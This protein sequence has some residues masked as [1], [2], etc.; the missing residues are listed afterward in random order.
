MYVVTGGAGFIGSNLVRGLNARGIDDI[1]VVDDL[2]QGDKFR[3]LRGAKI[4][5]YI[6]RAE[7]RGSVQ[8]G[9]LPGGVDA[10]FHQGACADT[11]E[12]NGRYMLDNNYAYS[13][14][15]LQCALGK[16]IPF[17]YA[18]SASVY[19]VNRASA[20]DP[21]NENPLNVYAYSKWLFDEYVRRMLP[22]AKSTVAGLRY[23][24]V[25]GPAER[26]KGRM[27]SMVYRLYGQLAEEGKARIFR[28]T[29]GFG[30]GEQRRDFVFVGD[31][32][33]VN[34]F[35][36]LDSVNDGQ[37]KK[38]IFN[39]GTGASRSFNDVA[40]TL[41]KLLGRGEVEHIPFPEELRGKYQSFTE[42]DVSGLRAAGY[43]KPFTSIED[44]VASSFAEWQKESRPA[45]PPPGMP[46]PKD[47]G[48]SA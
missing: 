9:A 48:F 35:F 31:C 33:D 27:A 5:D 46:G 38:G 13:K 40:G 45:P 30:D 26:H 28:G 19:G 43:G 16:G 25:Y 2:E 11:M 34:L 18:S 29:D 37:V 36:G 10:I 14:A 39:C 1:L 4:A 42:A 6:D 12:R 22:V 24:N 21:A 8:A 7:F 17:V 15:V 41:I 32:V 44:G 23:F 20:V 3:N 47:V